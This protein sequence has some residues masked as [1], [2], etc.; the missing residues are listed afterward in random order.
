MGIPSGWE[1]VILLVVLVALFGATKLP[2]AARAIGQS[3]RIFKAETKSARSQDEANVAAPAHGSLPPSGHPTA[4]L[5]QPRV[6]EAQRR[7]D[8]AR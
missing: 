6:N 4:G 1:L 2:T 7:D 3:I 8:T 5:A